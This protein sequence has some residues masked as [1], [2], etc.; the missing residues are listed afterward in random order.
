MYGKIGRIHFVGIGGSGMCGIAEV[1]LNLGY[2][3]SG[4]DLS[5]SAVTQ[6]LTSLGASVAQ[7]HRG[8]L[9]HGASVVVISTAVK[10]DNPE[11]TEARRLQI[12]VIARAEM[13]AELMRLKYGV[14]IAGAHGKTT[15]TSMVAAVLAGGGFDP[16]VVV[17]GRL[18]AAGA[19]AQLGGG[20]FLVAEADESDGSFLKLSPSIA[21]ITNID[22]EHLDHWKGGLPEIQDGFVT[23]ANKVP[24]YGVNVVCLESEAVQAVLPRLERRVV[25][26]GY[27]GAADYQ[28]RSI[29]THHDLSTTF[30][31]LEGDASLG[32]IRMRMP[33]QHNVLN[34]LAAI[35]VGRELE[36]SAEAISHAFAGF[37]GVA[38]RFEVKGEE[39]KVMVVDDYGHHPT[40]IAAVLKAAKDHGGRRV[41]ALFQPH[42]YTRTRDLLSQFGRAFYDADVV[43]ITDIY[44]AGEAP[45]EGLSG[46]TIVEEVQKHGHRNVHFVSDLDELPS[47]VFPNLQSEDLVLTLGAGNI[48]GTAD[49]LLEL[50][51]T[52]GLGARVS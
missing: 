18:K 4:S 13:L 50:L 12:P 16:T 26:Y 17:G 19:N 14:A 35:A 6:R 28:A 44:P 1:L 37:E 21:V 20:D 3:V 15:T 25:T 48:D 36:M 45:I 38:R 22:E 34:A 24:F 10:S 7:G 9:V 41:V 47:A 11:V 31:A 27:T 29:E 5:A 39:S 49:S 8:D 51:R 43:F 23:F 33:G 30:E 46:A 32:P 52:R 42:R 40:E 2:D